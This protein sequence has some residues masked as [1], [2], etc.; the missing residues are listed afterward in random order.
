MKPFFLVLIPLVIG[1]NIVYAQREADNWYFG[2]GAG[3]SFKSG[4][5][6]ALTDGVINQSEGVATISDANGNLLFY[7]DG[8]TIWNR[9]HVI[10]QNGTGLNGDN[11]SAQ[12]GVIVPMP[13][14]PGL[15]Y[16]FTVSNWPY[17]GTNRGLFYSVVD[18]TA[19]GGLGAV[20]S[21]N[22]LLH[23]SPREQVTSAFHANCRDVW[24]VSHEKGNANFLAY[25][26]TPTGI[27]LT[28][29]ASTVGMTYT[30][31]NRY[32]YLRFSSDGNKLCSTLGYA[33]GGAPA[34]VTVQLFDFDK[35]TGVVSNPV[36]LAN[37]V[38]DDRD[39]YGSEF[40][41]DNTKLYVC[42]YNRSFINQYDLSSG[43][44]AAILAS[45]VNIATG[46]A[47]KSCLQMGPDKK[48]YVSKGGQ[49]YLGVIR[50]PDKP[51]VLCDYVDD[52]VSLNGKSGAL[53]L[54]N[55]MQGFFSLPYLGVDSSI[56]PGVSLLLN[57]Y[58]R[59]GETYMWQ[60]GS[61]NA[62]FN[63]TQAGQYWVEVNNNGCVKRD[64]INIT[65]KPGSAVVDLGKDTSICLNQTL[66]LKTVAVPG[67]TYTW[68]DGSTLPDYTVTKTGIY[69]VAVTTTCGVLSDEIVVKVE[70]CNCEVHIPNAFSPNRDYR[71]DVFKPLVSQCRFAEYN[72]KIFN[73][74]GQRI[75][76]TSNPA[77]GWDGSLNGHLCDVGAYVYMVTYRPNS[78]AERKV[79][80]G[81]LML[82]R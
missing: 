60:D 4:A 20:T 81:T 50:D 41:A 53:G 33:T 59:P 73:R 14:N 23:A 25:L 19:A 28:P 58:T 80:H 45:K 5:P 42:A 34:V 13:N 21:K 67:A 64:E 17:T 40:S 9:D 12:S 63:V 76:E 75:F 22:V 47:I 36:T 74:W 39:S 44:A 66:V 51:G 27:S 54:P 79:K 69:K 49:T 11:Q 55:F 15:Y 57:A 70:D 31:G 38:G 46:S 2:G 37:A 77:A 56:C 78:D 30:G 6:V 43:N 10:M 24:I 16:V 18:M 62:T 29:V 48:I 68:Q 1:N 82:I 65:S 26:L 61:T 8:A 72:L 52:G 3:I 71:N 7:T 32:G 35:T